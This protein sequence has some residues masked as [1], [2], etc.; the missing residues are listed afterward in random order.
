MDISLSVFLFLV[1][2]NKHT[3]IVEGLEI[4]VRNRV[5]EDIQLKDEY[6]INLLRY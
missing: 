5:N 1:D 3:V 2:V 4:P 6:N